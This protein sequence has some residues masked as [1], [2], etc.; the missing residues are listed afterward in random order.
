M[1]NFVSELLSLAGPI[2][3]DINRLLQLIVLRRPLRF[4]LFSGGALLIL[5]R[6]SRIVVIV[7]HQDIRSDRTVLQR[8]A[9]GRVIFRDRQNQRGTVGNFQHLLNRAFT[10]SFVTDHIA[11]GILQNGRC[12]YLSRAGRSAIHENDDG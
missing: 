1:V 9:A 12:D 10:K 11:P 7:G 5:I 6:Q 4:C 3:Q 2:L 8:F